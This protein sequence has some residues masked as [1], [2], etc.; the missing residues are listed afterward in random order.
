MHFLNLNPVEV[1]LIDGWGVNTGLTWIKQAD[2]K[3]LPKVIVSFDDPILLSTEAGIVGATAQKTLKRRGYNVQF[4]YLKAWEHG[5]AL[6][7]ARLVC[8]CCLKTV[9]QDC[10]SIQSPQH[11]GLPPRPMRNLLLPHYKPEVPNRDAI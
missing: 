6:E 10:K 8:V 4:W 5:A 11:N 7:Q 9:Q 3:N 1:L 2:A